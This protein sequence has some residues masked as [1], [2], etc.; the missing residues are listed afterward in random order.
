LVGEWRFTTQ[1]LLDTEQA[2]V[3][4][5]ASRQGD[6]AGVVPPPMVDQV[7]AAHAHTET[8]PAGTGAGRRPGLSDEQVALV[9]ALVT[10]PDGVQLV[11][12]KAGSGK[13]SVLRAARHAWEAAGYRVVGVALAARA[14][15]ELQQSSGIAAAPSPG[16][17]A[18]ST[19]PPALAWRLARCW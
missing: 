6:A 17:S 9:R 18:T 7:I 11:N 4:A 5:A 8:S 15:R 3:L 10:S 14:A 19:I 12:A 1:E 2:A 13:T 16:S